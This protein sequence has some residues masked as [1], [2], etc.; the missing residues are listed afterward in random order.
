MSAPASAVSPALKA[1]LRREQRS[2][3]LDAVPERLALA[4][5]GGTGHASS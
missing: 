1:P 5:T 4:C 3:V 2:R